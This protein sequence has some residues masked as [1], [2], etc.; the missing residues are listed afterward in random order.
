MTMSVP[1]A[2]R[3]VLKSPTRARS[4]A[5]KRALRIQSQRRHLHPRPGAQ[6]VERGTFRRIARR[7]APSARAPVAFAKGPAP[8]RGGPLLDR[9]RVA[10]F[11][12]PGLAH[13]RSRAAPF[14]PNAAG[15]SAA[16]ARRIGGG[17]A[18][19]ARPTRASLARSRTKAESDLI[20]S[21]VPASAASRVHHAP[22]RRRRRDAGR[23]PRLE[24]QGPYLQHAVGPM[25]LGVGAPDEVPS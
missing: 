2:G 9:G 14:V 21:A 3:S 22:A 20:A 24:V 18:P 8:S 12:R 17:P 11:V 1:R 23:E 10:R 4:S 16:S 7:P 19:A 5:R 13:A 6:L 25:R 15:G